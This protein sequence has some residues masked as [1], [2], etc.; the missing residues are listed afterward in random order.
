MPEKGSEAP[1]IPGQY[2][3]NC[4]EVQKVSGEGSG[5]AGE[6]GWVGVTAI[7]RLV[8]SILTTGKAVLVCTNA[9]IN[10]SFT[11]RSTQNMSHPEAF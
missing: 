10:P 4:G 9:I 1:A 6:D 2:P 7:C 11:P 5:A 3:F 8:G